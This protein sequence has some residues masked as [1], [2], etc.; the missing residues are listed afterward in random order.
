MTA[1]V[2]FVHAADLHLAAPFKGVDATDPR[3]RDALVAAPYRALDAIVSLCIEERVDF[4]V[5]AGD[6][7]NAEEVPYRAEAAFRDACVKLAEAGIAVY[8]VR[9]NH[10]PASAR[11][12]GLELPPSVHVF[13]ATGVERVV[14]ERDGESVCAVY[15]RSFAR[16]AERENL[17][18]GFA[19][20][21]DDPHAVGVLHTNV[22]GRPGHEPYAPCSLEDLSAARMDYWALGHIHKPEVLSGDPAVV[23]AGC[24]QGLQPNESGARGCRLVTLA[25]GGARSEFVPTSQVMWDAAEVDLGEAGDIDSVRDAIGAAVHALAS[26]AGEVPVIARLTLVGRSAAHADLGRPGALAGLVE[27]ARADALARDPWVWLDRVADRTAAPIDLE[28]LRESEDLSGDLIRIA[29]ALGDDAGRLEEFVASVTGPVFGALDRRDVPE[30]DAVALLERA[31]TLA[32]DR[33]L[34][35]EDA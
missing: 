34:A 26:A 1:P 9:G 13:S 4:L 6:L 7:Y 27:E 2:R 12:F 5:V 17:A 21:A 16:A 28:A 15:G 30:T 29:D 23:Y 14:H 10:D 8:V 32:L 22:G 25:A 18:L 24:P 35:G 33:L 11:T 31:R 3:V 19:R 20:S